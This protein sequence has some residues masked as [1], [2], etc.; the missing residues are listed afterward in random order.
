MKFSEFFIRKPIFCIVSCL[1]LSLIGYLS[2]IDLPLRQ[3][4]NIEKSQ[5]S[6][7]T[8]YP[9]SAASTVETKI[10]EIIENQISGIE[11]IKSIS[12]VS[13]DGRS[14]VTIEFNQ[15]KNIDEAAND[16]R[17]SI[18]RVV[19]RLPKDSDSPEIYKI[20][21]DADAVMWLNLTSTNLSQMELTEYAER[22][23]V[24]RLSVVP[25]VARI[26]ISGQKKKSLRIWLDPK[27]LSLYNLTV[28]DVEN[29]L[30]EENVEFPAGRLESDTRDFTVRLLKNLETLE[31]FR[32]LVIKKDQSNSF[33]RLKDIAKVEIA[34]EEPRQLF[35]GNGEEMVGLGIVKQTSGNL[36]KVVAGIKD[37]FIK[38]EKTL[39]KNI[40]IYQSYDTSI[41]VSEALQDVIFTLCLAVL[42]V[43]IVI[44]FFL[45]SLKAAIIPFL[46]VPI[47]LIASFILLNVF[48]FSINLITLLALILCTGLVVDDSIVMLENIHRKIE[49]GEKPLKAAIFGSKEVFFAIV[50]TSIVLISVFLPIIFL[51]GDTAKLFDELALT[52]IGAI[53]FST[54]I[55]LT[56]TPMLC[57]QILKIYKVDFQKKSFIQSYYEKNIAFILKKKKIIIS[58]IIFLITIS[59][60]LYKNIAKELSPKE[61]RG[62]FFLIMN[63]PEGSSYKNT[64]Q[65][66][67]ILEEKLLEFNKSNEAN[68]ILLRVPRSFSGAENFSDGIG[69]IVLNHWDERRSIWKIINDV[70]EKTTNISDSKIQ[71]FPP[72]S[73]GQRRSGSQLQLVLGGDSY[74]EI[75]SVMEGILNAVS[76]NPNFVF[77]DTD[78][79]KNRPQLKIYIDRK[80]SSEL[81]VSTKEI[82]RTLEVLLGGRKINTFIDKG[83]EYYII[84]QSIS[85][86]RQLPDD[87]SLINVRS[88]NGDL[89]RLDSLI[90]SEESSAAKELHRYNRMRSITLKAG[91]NKDYSLGE[92]INFLENIIIKNQNEKI[93]VDYKGQ[94]KEFKDSSKQLIYLFLI[95]LLVVYLVLSAQFESFISPAI[96]MISVPLSFSGGLIGLWIADSSLNIFSQIGMI[97]LLGISAKNGILI[98]EFTNQLRKKGQET[99]E[100][101]IESCKKRFRP[102][103]MTGISTIVGASPLIFGN[104]AGSE[105][106]LT[107]GMVII[108]GIIFSTF[109]TLTITPFFYKLINPKVS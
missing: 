35:R 48:G 60:L 12:S 81:E 67:L 20:D 92:A 58:L 33:V 42:L 80:K 56:L 32:D 40:Y 95:S 76:K 89:I 4:P 61:D 43:T 99:S 31:N 45:R 82:G 108:G 26:R 73:L 96:I 9:G 14:K 62:A 77:V 57:S 78:Y 6:I 87:L 109:L 55:S 83:E 1:L 2:L 11:G 104:G 13:R 94:S 5:I 72:R 64:V 36:I 97:I 19:G 68:R 49:E 98:V 22:F 88:K 18:S 50:S 90:Y 52:I 38:I 15:N 30:I 39:P 44:L 79:K 24:D 102:I 37:E 74:S 10:T 107:I 75:D 65:Q 100:A 63:S 29:K 28:I 91:L 21:S 34:P 93:K 47:S 105:S 53:F 84:I 41:F 71:I 69:I 85:S 103:I 27:L 46:T 25:G 16:V 66:M 59:I 54:L 23:L 51:K 101:L 17:D 3:Y 106:R 7:D 86:E 70:K 8:R